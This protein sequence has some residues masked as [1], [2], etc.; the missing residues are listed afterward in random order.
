MFRA[1]VDQ[2]RADRDFL[3]DKE[4]KIP[5]DLQPNGSVDLV[6]PVNIPRLLTNIKQLNGIQNSSISDLEPRHYFEQMKQL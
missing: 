3:R 5:L 4:M 6:M 2:I 1:E